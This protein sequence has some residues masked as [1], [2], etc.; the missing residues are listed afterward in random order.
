MKERRVVW[1]ISDCEQLVCVDVGVKSF[2]IDSWRGLAGCS[3]P[4]HFAVC[5]TSQFSIVLIHQAEWQ[6]REKVFSWLKM[7]DMIHDGETEKQ[8]TKRSRNISL[9]CWQYSL[10]TQEREPHCCFQFSPRWMEFNR[11]KL[12]L[13]AQ[14][15]IAIIVHFCSLMCNNNSDRCNTM[16]GLVNIQLM[17]NNPLQIIAPLV[18]NSG[19]FYHG[20]FWFSN[21][22]MLRE[23]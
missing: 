19:A 14:S 11:L 9:Y 17:L 2:H 22:E 18:A 21:T 13:C 7:F 20:I 15:K 1:S 10:I 16:M 12:S 3:S 4:Q 5:G 23:Y 6:E 8:H